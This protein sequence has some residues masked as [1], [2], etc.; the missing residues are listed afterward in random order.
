[1]QLQKSKIHNFYGSLFCYL[2]ITDQPQYRLLPLLSNFTECH[3]S[4]IFHLGSS[5][6]SPQGKAKG[7][8]FQLENI[9]IEEIPFLQFYQ[10]IESSGFCSI[11]FLM[12]SSQGSTSI[13]RFKDRGLKTKLYYSPYIYISLTSLFLFPP[14]GRPESPQC[15]DKHT[16]SSSGCKYENMYSKFILC[17]FVLWL[18][19]S[20]LDAQPHQG[21]SAKIFLKQVHLKGPGLFFPFHTTCISTLLKENRIYP[22]Q[23]RI[24]MC[25]YIPLY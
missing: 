22:V 16:K 7:F 8:A 11:S 1:M 20:I 15:F 24:M 23:K 13:S 10:N 9:Q 25:M 12:S 3:C 6:L 5:S 18:S 19:S 2:K 17:R 4:K 21:H 14:S